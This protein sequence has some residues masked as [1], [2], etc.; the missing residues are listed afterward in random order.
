MKKNMKKKAYIQPLMLTEQIET[1][2]F[3]AISATGTNL[4]DLGVDNDTPT[5]AEGHSRLLLFSID[6]D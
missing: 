5:D 6:E 4:E 1:E 3:I 2:Q